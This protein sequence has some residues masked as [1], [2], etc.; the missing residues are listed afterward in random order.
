MASKNIG[1]LRFMYFI[2]QTFL[3][4]SLTDMA[5]RVKLPNAKEAE[6]YVLHMVSLYISSLKMN[7]VVRMKGICSTVQ[8]LP[9]LDTFCISKIIGTGSL[10]TYI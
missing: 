5:N 8:F 4:L 10:L 7:V 1:T 9:V 6:K 2:F 3:T